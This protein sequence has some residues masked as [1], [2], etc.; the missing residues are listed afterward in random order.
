MFYTRNIVWGDA[1]VMCSPR[2]FCSSLFY[3]HQHLVNAKAKNLSLPLLPIS[4]LPFQQPPKDPLSV[5][6]LQSAPMHTQKQ[7]NP[8]QTNQHNNFQDFLAPSLVSS[9]I[10]KEIG[11]RVRAGGDG[12]E[13]VG[14]GVADADTAAASAE[15]PL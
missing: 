1:Q 2:F 13:K 12:D 4:F 3:K 7:K 15:R 6:P 14:S 8:K 9:P 5:V 10:G 11:S